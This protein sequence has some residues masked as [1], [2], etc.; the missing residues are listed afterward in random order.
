MKVCENVI[1]IFRASNQFELN[2]FFEKNNF[3][4]I[5]FIGILFYNTL[6]Y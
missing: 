6:H 4:T 5:E 3:P 2:L 1:N